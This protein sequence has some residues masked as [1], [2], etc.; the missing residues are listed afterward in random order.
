MIFSPLAVGGRGVG[1]NSRIGPVCPYTSY[2]RTINTLPLRFHSATR[3][4]HQQPLTLPHKVHCP[5]G[6]VQT[7]TTLELRSHPKSD[8]EACRQKSSRLADRCVGT[9]CTNLRRNAAH[10][11][12]YGG[13]Q[14]ITTSRSF[15]GTVPRCRK[16][17]S[18]GNWLQTHAPSRTPCQD[19]NG[20]SLSTANRDSSR[21]SHGS[22]Q[23]LSIETLSLNS[24]PSMLP[25]VQETYFN[26][27]HR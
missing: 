10:S 14:R 9:V 24:E 25:T 11:C 20:F 17:L 16:R 6:G 2:I 4:E 19:N 22:D 18:V 26:L 5:R 15:A 21:V 13:S 3:I 1:P 7:P 12:R 23:I 27:G 8:C